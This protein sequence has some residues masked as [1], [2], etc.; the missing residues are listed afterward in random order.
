MEQNLFSYSGPN[1]VN[2][3]L[4]EGRILNYVFSISQK[5]YSELD[6]NKNCK[7]YPTQEYSSFIDCDEK[8]LYEKFMKSKVMPYWAAKYINETTINR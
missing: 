2:E 4:S 5:I 1:I 6:A 7:I 3:D 8:N